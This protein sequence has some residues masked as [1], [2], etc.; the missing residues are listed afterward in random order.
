MTRVLMFIGHYLP[1][2]HAGG[3]VRSTASMVESC[4]EVEFHI[5]TSDTDLKSHEVLGGIQPDRWQGRGRAQVFYASARNRTPWAM[6]RIVR[7]VRPDLIYLRSYFA[8]RFTQP[9]LLLRRLGLL[10]NVP[11]IL[12]AQGE[13]SPGAL[14]LKS[15]KKRLYRLL[16]R[17]LRMY[18]GLV[19][20]ARS[21][22]EVADIR[23]VQGMSATIIEAA[24]FPPGPIPQALMN[25]RVKTTYEA[26]LVFLSRISPKKNLLAA[27]EMLAG[28]RVPVVFDV[29]GPLEDAAYW[30]RCQQA[31]RTFPGN[32]TMTYRGE[33]E[34]GGAERIFASY[35]ALFLPTLGENFGYVMPEAWAAATPVLISDRT[36]WIDLEAKQAGWVVPLDDRAAFVERIEALAR[37]EEHEHARWRAGAYA[38]SIALSHDE[39]LPAAY[40]RLFDTALQ[41]G[42]TK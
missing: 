36:P 14:G 21:P 10:G 35:D 9:V 24:N 2:R 15:R 38:Y 4:H 18:R 25:H 30:A 28:V 22:L 31:A 6:R 39:T 11:I 27:I 29:Y 20:H 12:A 16:A 23:R 3:P 13:F 41:V 1:A 34:P 42:R 19:W 26:R 7:Q 37:M 17:G 32:V 33:V 5:F 40:C 8:W